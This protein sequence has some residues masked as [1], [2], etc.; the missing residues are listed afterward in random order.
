MLLLLPQLSLAN[1]GPVDGS[2]LYKTGNI[3]LQQESN[4]Q[5]I[6]ENLRIKLEDDYSIIV[7]DYWLENTSEES[8]EVTYG[9]PI[10]IADIYGVEG[11]EMS[12]RVLPYF[13]F[14]LN[15][16]TLKQR[17]RVEEETFHSGEGHYPY[18]EYECMRSWQ[19]ADLKLEAG[20]TTKLSVHYKVLNGF[21]DFATNKSIFTSY[22][23][24]RLIYD[25]SPTQHWGDGQLEHFSME[26][27]AS[28]LLAKGAKIDSSAISFEDGH[29]HFSA[30]NFDLK[31]AAPLILS[32]NNSAAK[33]AEELEKGKLLD[34][35]ILQTSINASTDPKLCSVL[36]DEDYKTAWI[37]DKPFAERGDTIYFKLDTLRT[38][39]AILMFNGNFSSE[40]AFYDY[41][42]IKSLTVDLHAYYQGEDLGWTDNHTTFYEDVPYKNPAEQLYGDCTETVYDTGEPYSQIR[43]LRI[44]INEVYPGRKHDHVSISELILIGTEPWNF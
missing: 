44:I 1:G 42:R 37:S 43:E 26:I 31:N 40:E 38:L 17:Q 14:L 41:S 20:A 6:E 19:L 12:T 39:C 18:E 16:D 34:K 7:V 5:L 28:S 9:F 35:E 21:E 25:F 8:S 33:Y 11:F 10:D 22:G 23:N 27:D 4:V 32:Y 36:R 15:G 2:D 3:V 29:Y 30:E 13:H 24:R